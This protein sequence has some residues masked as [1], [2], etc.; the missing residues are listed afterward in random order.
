[1][2]IRADHLADTLPIL[3]FFC[4]LRG[5]L[6]RI[7]PVVENA[8]LVNALERARRRAPFLSLVLAIEIFHRVLVERY[9]RIAA[10]LRAPVD[11]TVF[12]DIEIT[13]AGATTPVVRLSFS[14]AVLKPVQAGVVLVA[15]L[16]HLL[17]DV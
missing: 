13:R 4:E 3:L 12:A 11:E 6:L 10:L 9:A 15:H 2:S 16:L 7:A 8:D 1:M 5:S 17:K 14:D